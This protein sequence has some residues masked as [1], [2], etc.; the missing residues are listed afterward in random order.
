[1]MRVAALNFLFI[2]TFAVC[3][4]NVAHAQDNQSQPQSLGDVARQARAAKA[5]APKS[6]TVLDDDNMPKSKGGTGGG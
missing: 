1:M 6:A 4:A 2:V 5:S 3:F